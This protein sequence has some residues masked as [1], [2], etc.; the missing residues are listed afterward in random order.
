MPISVTTSGPVAD[1]MVIDP[2][3]PTFGSMAQQ[4]A[5]D[6]DDTTGEY[7]SQIARA[8][9]EAIRYCEREPFYFNQTREITFL[10]VNGQEFY[11]SDAN[12]NIPTLININAAWTEDQQGQRSI[13]TRAAPEELEL[14]SD[15]SA[16]Q[17]EP[18][19]F[20]YFERQIRLYPIP[21]AYVYNIR[22]QASNYRLVPVVNDQDTNAW[23]TEAFDMVKA[24]AKYILAKNT[25]KDAAVA[26]EALSDFSDQFD[27]LKRESSMRLSRGVIIATCW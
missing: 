5:D 27:A 24:R 7:S 2:F 13:L 25:T 14:L 3:A 4:I 9:Q 21:D 8:I 15:N 11:G 6:I 22:L 18:Y 26:A 19:W 10:T 16:G 20:S 23:F 17:G 12:A 1:A